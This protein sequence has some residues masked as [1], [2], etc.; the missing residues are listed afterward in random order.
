MCDYITGFPSSFLRLCLETSSIDMI[1]P[2][3]PKCVASATE[4]F[5]LFSDL[6]LVMY[7]IELFLNLAVKGPRLAIL[8][9]M[10]M[11]DGPRRGDG[12]PEWPEWRMMDEM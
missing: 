9:S 3:V 8:G 1:S 5:V 7:T 10:D 2:S 4:E 6:C 12:M 11:E